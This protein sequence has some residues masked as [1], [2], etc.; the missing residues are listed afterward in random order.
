M[1]RLLFFVGAMLMP[2]FLLAQNREYVLGD[3]VWMKDLS[4]KGY[5]EYSPHI[6]GEEYGK[7]IHAYIYQESQC[8]LEQFP[9]DNNWFAYHHINVKQRFEDQW[10]VD[11]VIYSEVNRK[12]LE[13]NFRSRFTS[14]SYPMAQLYNQLSTKMG[15]RGR[16]KE[17]VFYA[18]MYHQTLGKV[19]PVCHPNHSGAFHVGHIYNRYNLD[20]SIFWFK[21]SAD[22]ATKEFGFSVPHAGNAYLRVASVYIRTSEYDSAIV[23]NQKALNALL[24]SSSKNVNS[25]QWTY[26]QLL[27]MTYISNLIPFDSSEKIFAEYI[28][29]IEDYPKKNEIMYDLLAFVYNARGEN[30]EHQ[31]K[32]KEAI[33]NYHKGIKVSYNAKKN[34][35]LNHLYDVQG[36]SKSL[37]YLYARLDVIYTQNSNLQL[38]RLYQR[39]ADS[40]LDQFS[41]GCLHAGGFADAIKYHDDSTEFYK[42]LKNFNKMYNMFRKTRYNGT[43][44]NKAILNYAISHIELAEYL[45]V[46][47]KV[48]SFRTIIDKLISDPKL[49]S[50]TVFNKTLQLLSKKKFV[51]NNDL[52]RNQVYLLDGLYKSHSFFDRSV[53]YYLLSKIYNYDVDTGLKYSNLAFRRLF[54]DSTYNNEIFLGK[55]EQLSQVSEL[56]SYILNLLHRSELLRRLP[57]SDPRRMVADSCLI[58]AE[59][60][61]DRALANLK[62]MNDRLEFVGTLKELVETRLPILLERGDTAQALELIERN[63]ARTLHLNHVEAQLQHLNQIPP[64]DRQSLDSLN[65]ALTPID[66]ELSLLRAKAKPTPD[67]QKRMDALT[68]QKIACE[69]KRLDVLQKIETNIPE[70]TEKL[71]EKPQFSVAEFRRD[72]FSLPE[73]QNTVCLS[74]FQAKDSLY[75]FLLT[76]NKILLKVLPVSDSLVNAKVA[77]LN[78]RMVDSVILQQKTKK[79]SLARKNFEAYVPVASELYQQL[80]APV[81]DELK[82]KSVIILPDNALWQL[83]FE[84]LLTDKISIDSAQKMYANMEES[85]YQALPYWLK[86]STISR[87]LSLYAYKRH[88]PMTYDY[89]LVAFAPV[90]E[91]KQR[92]MV[93]N[94]LQIRSFLRGVERWATRSTI[95]ADGRTL[96]PL[97]ET[98]KEIKNISKNFNNKVQIRLKNDATERALKSFAG[99]T[100]R[101]FHIAT[102]G[103][104]N[105]KQTHLSGLFFYPDNEEDG[106]LYSGEVSQM[107]FPCYLLT[108]S[109]CET[110]KGKMV[111]GEGM[112]GLM[113]NFFKSGTEN[114]VSSLWSVNDH[115]TAQLMGHFYRGI[116][117]NQSPKQALN[118]AKKAVIN[119]NN[120]HPYYWSAFNAYQW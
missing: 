72:F 36:I 118:Q 77:Y 93:N 119:S 2:F 64:E 116:A 50:L 28:Q 113:Y 52:Y 106:A 16:K 33:N 66:I 5:F 111:S 102:H 81:S 103:F 60:A 40:Y 95:T 117:E 110:G 79:A 94:S 31:N 88:K 71:H 101:Y 98:L 42:A 12:K 37:H 6:N 62:N 41:D 46:V 34:N 25:I 69:E 114:I 30:L 89:D 47:E 91:P 80:I 107:Q 26:C 1:I 9:Q 97:Y 53:M 43:F 38:S 51:S 78:A 74:Y 8:F 115:S 10:G 76:P 105:L 84:A 67:E 13:E 85:A 65:N 20:S 18:L 56:N 61:A 44:Y 17:A 75:A 83:P 7:Q 58:L 19:Y 23:Y 92:H 55:P 112:V 49:Y 39:T 32:I 104:A 108:L 59:Q 82:G 14:I 96:V 48:D 11:T 3:T 68:H 21:K 63:R 29:F 57:I 120:A 22:W 45:G 90:F 15:S 73:N 27:Q 87:R 35:V 100:V 4:E 70:Y 24:V 99:K 86:I 54:H 109:A